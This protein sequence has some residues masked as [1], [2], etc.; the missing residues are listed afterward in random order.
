MGKNY[1]DDIEYIPS[2]NH[3]SRGGVKPRMVVLHY[4]ADTGLR[5][6]RFFKQKK[7]N[8]SAH[9]VV[10]R[11]GKIYQMVDLDRTAWHAGFNAKTSYLRERLGII[12]PNRSS[13]GIEIVN[14][15][16]LDGMGFQ[17]RE[18]YMT[19]FDEVIPDNE[20]MIYG[21]TSSNPE[22]QPWQTYS[23]PQIIAVSQ[24]VTSLCKE[25]DIPRR[26]MFDDQWNMDADDEVKSYNYDKR[27]PYY[28]PSGQRLN[29]LRWRD[30][31]GICGHCHISKGKG[32]PGPAIELWK[33]ALGIK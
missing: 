18:Y 5:A 6:V 14:A 11:D 28:L 12:K 1:L 15:G 22:G 8:A 31:A 2:P 32:D 30:N 3:G 17:A 23:E 24:L 7:A 16:E 25:L 10:Q 13:V 33:G 29:R 4:T 9:Y 20:V 21:K 26:F 27:V 19:W